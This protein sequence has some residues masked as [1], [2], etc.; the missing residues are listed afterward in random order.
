MFAKVLV[1][2]RGEIAV[3][4]IRALDELGIESVAVYS[5]ADRDAQHV[6][7]ATEAYLLGIA[8]SLLEVHRRTGARLRVVSAGSA[9]LG[10]LDPMVDRVDWS[11]AGV[12]SAL[13]GSDV[14]L[15]PLTDTPYARGKSAY[16]LLQY[17]ATG[18]P[19]VAS[20]VGANLTALEAFGGLAERSA[21]GWS[22]AVIGLLAAGE[23]V[24]ARLGSIARRGVEAHYSF[25]R[26]AA[27]W[28]STVMG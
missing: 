17:A 12:G 8:P 13:A 22:E 18:L 28:Q 6:K 15:G 25:A 21:S 27:T 7:R 5:E 14:A 11:E 19:M 23:D 4:V 1:A 24:R 26:W 3:R 10:L 16:K 20:P 2:N 9:S